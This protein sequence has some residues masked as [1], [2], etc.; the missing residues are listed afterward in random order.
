M[1]K[2]KKDASEFQSFNKDLTQLPIRLILTRPGRL[3][4]HRESE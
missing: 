1:E 4:K 2:E 3:L